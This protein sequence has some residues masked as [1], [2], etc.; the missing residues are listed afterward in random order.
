VVEFRL[1]GP[2]GV[3]A[4]DT[5]LDAG[6]PRQRAVLAALAVDA[7]RL[8]T[9]ETLVDRVWGDQPPPKARDALYA[10]I[11]RIRRLLT[12]IEDADG[13]R[14]TVVRNTGGY[15]LDVP[16]E[17]VD[18]LRFRRLTQQARADHRAPAD[19]AE[20]LAGALAGWHGEPLAGIQGAWADRMRHTWTQERLDAATRWADLQLT[21]GRPDTVPPVLRPV[22]TEHPL[23]ERPVA[24]LMR[25][26]AA[27]GRPAEALALFADLRRRLAD[28]LGT[29]PG[30]ELHRLH[31]SV[32]RGKFDGGDVVPAPAQLPAGRP[33]FTGR[34]AE[35]AALDGLLERPADVPTVVVTAVA[36]TAGVGKTTL[37]VHWAHRIAD[38]FP[39]GQ[40]YVNLRGFDPGG[41]AMPPTIAV[42]GFL[43]AL[44]VPDD[45]IP[46]GLDAQTGLYRSL[47]AGK[48]ILVLLDNARD[49]EHARPLL[50][51]TPT[52][53]AV[54]TS[55]NPL[56]PLVADGA[57]P[58][59]L[60]LLSTA[61]AHALLAKRIEPARVTAEPGA[62]D[63]LITSCAR[64]PL[65]LA[66]VAARAATHPTFR[67]AALAAEL[68]AA[69]EPGTDD[70]L[71][72]VRTV[73]SW[74]YTTLSPAAARLFRLLGLH[75][76]P[77]LSTAAAASLAAASPGDTR[78]S[79]TELTRAGLLTEPA[80]GRFGWHDLLRVYATDLAHT[81]DSAAERR[82]A[83]AR[84]LDH[85][86]HSAHTAARRL[87]PNR[88]E[89]PL[90]LGPPAAGTTPD[91]PADLPAALAWM[92][93]ER[94]VLLAVQRLAA[95]S[96]EAAQAWQLAW[97]MDTF[98][99]RRGR[100]HDQV[101]SWQTAL[102]VAGRLDDVT[103]VG[104]AHRRLAQAYSA[105]D[106]HADARA[107]LQHSLE[108][109]AAAGDL[110]QQA[111]AHHILAFVAERQGR[112]EEAL[113]H[114][115]DAL[116][117]FRSVGDHKGEA[118]S[119][120]GVGWY[121]TLRGAHAAA[122]APCQQ[123]LSLYQA[124]GDR[125]GEAVTWDSLGH[126]HQHLGEH[127]AAVDCYER[128]V[129]LY[130]EVGDRYEEAVTLD[131][132]GDVHSAAGRVDAARAAWSDA[133]TIFI[134]LRRPVAADIQVKLAVG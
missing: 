110:R 77:D 56:T 43:D 73:F 101:A 92:I 124:A 28:E 57:H 38:R 59:I 96:G 78:R 93:A 37:A 30:R 36:G 52:A 31:E 9:V 3:R 129:R 39:D 15:V 68:A 114:E 75:P 24:V 97:A 51:G 72:Q 17:N 117:L 115:T 98:L 128:A 40:L 41:D 108:L 132:L 83:T 61:D 90:P 81:V 86:T 103:T 22:I 35:L 55:R 105:L 66:L 65:A 21:M 94:P 8:V 20:D 47:L 116:E 70:V 85:F 111:R 63:A 53:L 32:L 64:L 69:G 7:G 104:F 25:A 60:D 27:T 107:H 42:R 58:L 74:S 84:L 121:Q 62:V 99:N 133:L 106:A 2:V 4:G 102:A 67:L 95:G 126:A 16:P 88:D 80:P 125:D 89:I 45:R 118:A 91:V 119:L 54:V 49:A 50:P 48:R 10:Y 79:L 44:G 130:R 71:S 134:E 122:L 1:L 33:D 120:N 29:E 26:L 12:R 13:I 100:W 76:G 23:A 18:W 14:R 131:K 46:A 11:T 82:A 5:E 123:A 113:E 109:F 19:R 6:L 127:A 87:Y 34:A 112:S